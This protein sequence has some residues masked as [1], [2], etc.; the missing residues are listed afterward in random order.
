MPSDIQEKEEKFVHLH[1]HTQY[2]PLDGAIKIKELIPRLKELGMSSCAITD[3]GSMYGIV[4]F[5]KSC[6]AGGIHPV[7]GS[8]FYISPGSLSDRNYERGEDSNYHLVLLA[9]NNTGLHN[10]YQLSSIAFLDGFYRKPRI[11]KEILAKYSEGVIALS[12]CLGGEIARKFLKHGYKAALEAALEYDKIMGRGNYF[13]EIQE[14]GIPEQTIVNRQLVSISRETG[15][16]LVATCDCHY[17]R[18][19]DHISHNIL[20]QVQYSQ[21]ANME[22]RVKRVPPPQPGEE[23]LAEPAPAPSA[24]ISNFIASDCGPEESPAEEAASPAA[25]KNKKTEYSDQLYVKSPEEIARDFAY[26]PEAVENTVK[27]ARR[28]DVSIKFG[29]LRLPKYDVPEGYTIETY[30]T[31]LA[32]NGLKKRLERVPEEKHPVYWQRLEE[33]I[34]V[35]T[36][37]G[38]DGYFLIVWDFINYSRRTGIPVGPGRGSGA[39][40]LVAYSLE[41]TD[42]DPIRFNLLFERFLNPERVSMPDFDIDFC[43]NGRDEVIKYVTE[44]YGHDRVCQI[45]TFGTLKPRMAV[46]DVGRVFNILLADVDK[47]AKAIPEGPAI[48]SFKVAFDTDPS[49][50]DTF[51]KYPQGMELLEHAKNIEGLIRNIGMHAAGVIIADKPILEY[52]PLCRG[53]KG[54]VITQFEKGTSEKIGL[55]KFDF[56][57]LKNL[58]IIDDAVKR[59]RRSGF[60]DFDISAVPLDDPE[61]FDLLQRGDTMGVFQL[62]SDG[63]KSLLKKLRPTVFEDIIAV[64]AL[65][66]PGPINSGMLDDF[67]AR[68]HGEQE[69]VYALPELAE[70]LRETYGIIVYQE[71]VMQIACAL[72]GYTLGSADI[73]RRAM[74][75]KDKEEMA[76]Q[77][78]IFLEGNE[79]TKSES[80]KLIPGARAMGFDMEKA[81]AVFDLMAQF[82]EYGFNKSHS[83]AY[84]LIAY[85]TAYMKVKFPRQYMSALISGDLNATGDVVKYIAESGRLGIK[86][87]PPDINKSQCDFRTEGEGIRFGLGAIK[88]AGIAVIDAFIRERDENGPYKSIYDFTKRVDYKNLNRKAVESLIKAGAFDSFGKNRRQLLQVFDGC[89]DEG[90]KKSKM[91]EKGFFTLEDFMTEEEQDNEYYPD[92]EEMPEKELLKM[93]KEVLGFYFSSHPLREISGFIEKIGVS[94]DKIRAMPSE[95]GV[96]AAGMI[97]GLRHYITKTK[98]EKMAF[99]TLEDLHGEIDVVIFPKL[100]AAVAHL[101]EEDSIIAV[102]GVFVR[103]GEDEEKVSVRAEEVVDLGEAIERFTAGVTMRFDVSKCAPDN[104]FQLRTVLARHRG[105]LPVRV[106]FERPMQF[107]VMLK[108]PEDYRIRPTA[109]FLSDAMSIPGFMEAFAVPLSERVFVAE[110]MPADFDDMSETA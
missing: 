81:S 109:D 46:R 105:S 74:G 10:L 43:I 27:I 23:K 7:I 24:D 22:K 50:I 83:A 25:R 75:K 67:V 15:I 30:F 89:L 99:V 104:M 82:A 57:G 110:D 31:T 13:L 49:L 40:S 108:M 79:K 5:Y 45:I 106:S 41:I 4:D 17:L 58:T 21:G 52:A 77:R 103:D 18:H 32:R 37:K 98:R 3:H 1:L 8:E 93:E 66:R 101:L 34:K 92:V 76:R 60:P 72:G 47:M 33:E 62:E 61:V 85:Q 96:V 11:D 70:I 80:D 84:A 19:E 88:S 38:F 90:Y 71:Q 56:L 59:I 28:C 91:K 9:E 68:K 65:Y 107:R 86:V 39:G 16:P 97:K 29:E 20:M 64:N 42:I 12:A 54:E 48:T 14:N 55:I 53:P 26:A 95:S 100:Y 63:M 51:K 44:R 69:I 102:R 94:I 35:I 2:S 6:K 87:L 73:L 78:V 36:L